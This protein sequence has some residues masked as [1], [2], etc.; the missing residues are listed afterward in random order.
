MH[1]LIRL[2]I[3]SVILGFVLAGLFT[4]LL[5]GL[6]VAHLRHLVLSSSLGW[7]A[8]LMLVFFN[9]LVFSGVQFA[10]RV[11]AMAESHPPKGGRRQP[12]MPVAVPVAVPAPR[13][14]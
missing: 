5:L 11:M 3:R 14:Q 10:I 8:V 9:G 13:R 6:D 2:Y 4:G 12:A 7:L 1:P